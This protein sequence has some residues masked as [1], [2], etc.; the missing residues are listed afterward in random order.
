MGRDT[1]TYSWLTDYALTTLSMICMKKKVFSVVLSALRN[2]KGQ[3]EVMS[4]N[5]IGMD[6]PV[7]C[8]F[9]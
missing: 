4:L 6:K 1:M 9:I 3:K 8:S 2:L 5:V 7:F